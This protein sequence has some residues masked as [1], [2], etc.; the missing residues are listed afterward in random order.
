MESNEEKDL[1]MLSMLGLGSVILSS[2][3]FLLLP[4]LTPITSLLSMSDDKA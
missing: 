1:L 3:S 4:F 2:Y